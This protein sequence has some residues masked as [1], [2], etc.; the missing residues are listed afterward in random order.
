MDLEKLKE[1]TETNYLEDIAITEWISTGVKSLNFLISGDYKKGIPSGR[2]I[3]LAGDKQSGKS[4]IAARSAAN[5]QKQ[6]YIIMWLDSEGGVD[7]EYLHRAGLNTKETLFGTIESIEELQ[8]KT[9]RALDWALENGKKMF[10]IIDSV[11]NLPSSKE[12]NDAKKEEQK[13]DMGIKA[14]LIRSFFRIITPKLLK[15]NSI[16]IVIN[17]I[18]SGGNSFIPTTEM[19]GG[20]GPWYISSVVLFLTKKKVPNSNKETGIIIKAKTEKNRFFFPYRFIEF[21]LDFRKGIVEE[22]TLLDIAEE[23][24]IIEKKGGWYQIT[25]YDKKMRGAE[26][27]NDIELFNNII[28]KTREKTS[29][30]NYYDF[31]KDN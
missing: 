24:N 30:D 16:M 2:V 6:D 23:Y 10:L 22:Q 3:T 19:G 9:N 13:S 11:G 15:T 1:L 5:A 4:F 31:N 12:I 29:T 7:K 25:G 18:Y 17:H 28:E 26:I 20:K 21:I 27:I 8:I 14:K